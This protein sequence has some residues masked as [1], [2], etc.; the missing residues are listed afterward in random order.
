MIN[1]DILY[2]KELVQ[3]KTLLK[4]YPRGL[5]IT[6][7]SKEIK[8][9]RNSV[10][11]YMDVLTILGQVEM[12]ALG[13]AKVFYTAQRVPMSAMLNFS[14]DGILVLNN[15]LN[16]IQ[17]NDN[18][19]KILNIEREA[20]LGRGIVDFPNSIFTS[21]EMHSR[22]KEA[23]DGKE[24]AFEKKIQLDEREIYFDI[25]MLPTTFDDGSIGLTWI[26]QDITER[27]QMEEELRKSER[28]SSA[29]IEA[30]RALTFSYDITSGHINWGGAIEEITGYT[31]EDFAQVDFQDWVDK[32]HPDDK[33]EVL[34]IL[35]EAMGKDRAT[36][37]YRF[38]TKKGYITVSSISL[39][40]K[41]DGKAV[42]LVG[43]LQDIT[44]RKKTEKALIESE[45]RFRSL[46]E[47]ARE[48]ILFSGP[49]GKIM[50]VNS[51]T[52]TMLGYDSPEELVGVPAVE[53]YQ[54]PKARE[55][56]F[57]EIME[58]GYVEQYELTAKK[59]DG[60]PIHVL[61]S[62]L[63]RLD[64]EGNILQ[65]EAFFIDITERKKTEE[66]LRQSEE[67]YRALFV[68][69]LN[70]Y[71]YCKIILDEKNKPIDFV[72]IE[73]NDAFER[74]TGLKKE[75]VV[76]KR[77]TEAISGLEEAHSELFEVYGRV[78]LTG[79]EEVFDIDFKP[80]NMWLHISVYSPR[81]GYFVAIFENI[82]ERK[83]ME[84][85]LREANL[86]L[87]DEIKELTF[88]YAAIREMQTANS[89]EDL[90]PK[91][92]D[93][94]VQAMQFPEIAT[95]VVKI[96]GKRFAHKRYRENL[97]H[98]IHAEIC[99][100]DQSIGRVSVYYTENRPFTIPHE[101]NMLNMLADNLGGW[102]TVTRLVS[103]LT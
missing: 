82:T 46:F 32:I 64:D 78:A 102:I 29:A 56:M 70:G 7:I 79:K 23:L 1:L 41:Q 8:V 103:R 14:S 57:K 66:S 67:K 47:S 91:L 43:I 83:S 11:R 26:L 21:Q 45:E 72:Y 69:M 99:I 85:A 52:A 71:A 76:G 36:A 33:D 95:P 35:Q 27:K 84:K 58:K 73:V 49:E 38:K 42:R 2:K 17:I 34:S 89:A 54:D 44:E 92:V 77:V 100:D 63:T 18:L 68:N 94:L 96:E 55:A 74:L 62:D 20:I 6:D 16:I 13:P 39:T 51:A 75:D 97:T 81:K 4:T 48:G 93:L 40:E 31:P 88:F 22:V 87:R 65:T 37:K 53:L 50:R 3:I 80:L 12:R 5:T 24:V 60:S 86:A 101:Q 15:D 25:K 28:Q 90:V 59:R 10:A 30:A 61:C 9:N 98:G 19:L